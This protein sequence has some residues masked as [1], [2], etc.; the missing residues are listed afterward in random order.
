MF[1]VKVFASKLSAAQTWRAVAQLA[2]PTPPCCASSPQRVFVR[3]T[4]ILPMNP[5]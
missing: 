3:G 1:D 4:V 2:A 5:Q